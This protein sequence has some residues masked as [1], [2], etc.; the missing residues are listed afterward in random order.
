MRK[1]IRYVNNKR[2]MEIQYKKHYSTNLNRDMEYKTYGE[3][4]HP[5]LVF[6]SQDGRFYDYQDFDMV[7]TLSQLS[8]AGRF[9]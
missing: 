3:K 8:T 4:G 2:N 1:P 9:A 5:V 6:P 7:G